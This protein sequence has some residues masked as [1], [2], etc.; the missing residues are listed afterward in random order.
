MQSGRYF[1]LLLLLLVAVALLAQAPPTRPAR[2]KVLIVTGVNNHDWR[3][4]SPVLREILEQTGKFD[5]RIN[6]EMRGASFETFSGYDAVLL[7]WNDWKK[8]RG[9]WWGE[10][11]QEGLLEY[12]RGGKG[13]VVYHASNNAFEGWEEY[14]K[15]V[16]GTWRATAGHAPIHTYT[17]DN[18]APEHPIMKGIPPFEVTDELYHKLSMQPNIQLLASAFDDPKNCTKNGKTCGTGK[19]EP[20]LWTVAYGSGRV[21]QTALGHNVEAMKA[22]GFIATL[23]R[24]TEW[25]ATGKVTIPPMNQ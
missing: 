2:L 13:V 22:P 20:L 15:L 25:A 12:V 18:K 17:V 8:T 4:T 7:N 9:P 1:S 16:G 21:F 24:G 14:D 11:A 5:V 23:Q 10:R 6:E 19:R 3:A